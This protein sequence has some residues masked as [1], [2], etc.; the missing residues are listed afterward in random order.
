MGEKVKAPMRLIANLLTDEQAQKRIKKKTDRGVKLGKDA[1]EGTGLNLFV[2]NIEIEKCDAAAIYELYR[3]RWQIE[4]I[5]KAWKSILN[6]HKIHTMNAIRLECLLWIKL[7]WVLLNWSI[8]LFA[9]RF[10]QVELSFYKL[11]R[12]MLSPKVVLK[13]EILENVNLLKTWLNSLVLVIKIYSRKE[14]KK[15]SKSNDL[16][17]LTFL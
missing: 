2:T 16:F 8:L 15:G 13:A 10:S 17:N 14:Y 5:F 3:L 4:L 7:L 6:L 12:I 1:L 11:S 9:Q